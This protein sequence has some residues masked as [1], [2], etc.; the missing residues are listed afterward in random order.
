VPSS[1]FS[2]NAL[3]LSLRS[4]AVLAVVL[5]AIFLVFPRAWSRAQRFEAGTD[6]RFPY[7]TSNDYWMY[8]QWC[9]RAAQQHPYLALGDSVIWGQY[10][11]NNQTL[12]HYLNASSGREGEDFANIAIDGIHPIAMEG[13]VRYYGASMEGRKVLINLNLL[14]MSSPMQDFQG[15]QE[16]RFNHP[17]LV[18]QVVGR[19]A[20]YKPNL[21]EVMS[22]EAERHIEFF[23]CA[24]HIN[25]SCF[26]NMPFSDW[27]LEH[28]YES[29]L[30]A[31]GTSLPGTDV[32]PQSKPVDWKK[33]GMGGQ[34]FAWVPLSESNQWRAF[35]RTLDLLREKGASVFVL[36][37]P[38]N[39]YL[40]TDDSRARGEAQAKDAKAWLEG[41]RLPYYCADGLQ[42]VQYADASHPLADGYAEIARRLRE[43]SAFKEWMNK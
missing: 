11:G 5:G 36:F 22:V 10:A 14:W 6:Y 29:P 20:C 2:S 13:L 19:F 25:I 43:C 9:D 8:R 27:T 37:V 24:K 16:F 32:G 17:R 1:T 23:S 39:P 15:D 7:E 42:S 26:A 3:R 38:I 4:W 12:T 31:L 33:R 34:D 21:A 35:T 40:Q 18:P 41:A 30:T 28:P